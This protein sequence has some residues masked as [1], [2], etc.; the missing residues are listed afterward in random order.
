MRG[1]L[2]CGLCGRRM[3]GAWNNGQRTV[4]VDTGAER[5]P[6]G[7]VEQAA[8]CRRLGLELTYDHH[9]RSISR[10]AHSSCIDLQSYA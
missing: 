9:G 6:R 1:L 2:W 4:V 5:I 3:Q 7:E 8:L 10:A